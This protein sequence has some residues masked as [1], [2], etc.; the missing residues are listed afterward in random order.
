[1]PLNAPAPM[2]P[3][4]FARISRRG[5][6]PPR[7]NSPPLSCQPMQGQG[8]QM[9]PAAS[10]P[11]ALPGVGSPPWGVKRSRPRRGWRIPLGLSPRYSASRAIHP[12][13][14]QR[15]R[16]LIFWRNSAKIFIIRAA[17][18]PPPP[19]PPIGGAPP[20]PPMGGLYLLTLR[21][22]SGYGATAF[23]RS[24]FPGSGGFR[25]PVPGP[26]SRAGAAYRGRVCAG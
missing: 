10:S 1:M 14:L 6:G 2:A 17:A 25:S 19:T 12:K 3:S 11:L 4:P 16:R 18:H 26:R 8:A 23:Y 15:S 24:G 9:R 21:P 7:I 22:A 5:L 20:N 13:R